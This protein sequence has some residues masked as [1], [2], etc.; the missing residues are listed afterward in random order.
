MRSFKDKEFGKGL[1]HRTHEATG[2][3]TTL[4]LL[5]APKAMTYYPHIGMTKHE[6][7]CLIPRQA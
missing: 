3:H 6:S 4:I 7:C 2:F 5:A 1:I